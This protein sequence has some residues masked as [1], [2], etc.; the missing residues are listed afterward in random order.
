MQRIENHSRN[1]KVGFTLIE[2]LVVI[3]IIAILA[4]ILFPAFAR[5]RENARRSSCQSNLKQIGLG[6]MQY[7]QDYDEMFPYQ[8]TSGAAKFRTTTTQTILA[9]VQPYIKS[10]QVYVCPSASSVTGTT[11]PGDDGDTNYLLNMVLTLNAFTG[12]S[13]HI[14]SLPEPASLILVQDYKFRAST[15]YL[16]PYRTTTAGDYTQW[17]TD[18]NYNATHFDGGNLLFADGHVKWRQQSTICASEF[19]LLTPTS[20]AACGVNAAGSA[21]AAF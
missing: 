19:G 5:A 14:S 3:A 20:G 4:A 21:R 6:V 1:R 12:L 16:R 9:T 15:S 2:L 18:A 11:A 7:T 8:G 17:L 10:W 13:R